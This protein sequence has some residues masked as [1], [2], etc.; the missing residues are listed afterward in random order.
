M[1]GTQNT[2]YD[3][4]CGYFSQRTSHA[5]IFSFPDQEEA[6][7]II[8]SQSKD[9]SSFFYTPEDLSAVTGEECQQM[10]YSFFLQ[11]GYRRSSDIIY[12][13]DCPDCRK[14]VPI[15]I[16]TPEFSFSKKQR[17]LLRKNKSIQLT[18]TDNQKDFLTP[19]KIHLMS[20]YEKRHDG[21]EMTLN[22]A[23]DS[24]EQENGI[25][26]SGKF[27][28]GTMNMEYRIDSRLIA[29][30][31]VDKATNALSS[32]YFYYD[33]SPDMMKR[34]LGTFSILKEIEYCKIN[35]IEWY[36]LGYWISDCRKMSYKANF[37]PHQLRI[38]GTWTDINN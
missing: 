14:C 9:E 3:S 21:K 25:S 7:E 18:T 20:I 29:C 12:R 31:I 1:S 11:E 37:K 15:R 19:D 16:H 30:G 8:L 13:E 17:Y 5:S 23:K 22:N 32:N 35:N 10:I 28:S 33:I 38:K 6:K 34:S 36:Y 4:P 27:Y 26:S 24:L 2:L